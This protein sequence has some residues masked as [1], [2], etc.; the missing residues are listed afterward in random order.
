MKHLFIIGLFLFTSTSFAQDN[1]KVAAADIRTTA[2]CDMC[3][4]TIEGDLIYEKGVKKVEVRLTDNII[5]VEFDP[6]KTT[7]D[8]I[9][10][11]ITELGYYADDLP[12]NPKAFAD[13]PACCQKEGCGQLHKEE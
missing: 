3:V 5:H 2:V 10:T 13:L 6:R 7:I 8:A 11:A 9:R 1:K 12:A 4:R